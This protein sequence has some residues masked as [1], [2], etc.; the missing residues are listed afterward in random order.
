[1]GRGGAGRS[2]AGEDG[3]SLIVSG[4]DV[5]RLKDLVLLETEGFL[6]ILFCDD[7]IFCPILLSWFR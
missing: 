2:R 5:T 6:Y 1:M 4:T 3:M 7:D